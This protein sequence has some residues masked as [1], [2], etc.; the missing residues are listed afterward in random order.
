RRPVRSLPGFRSVSRPVC[1]LRE[2]TGHLPVCQREQKD[3]RRIPFVHLSLPVQLFK[4]LH[5]RERALQQRPHAGKDRRFFHTP[6]GFLIFCPSRLLT[7]FC[8]RHPDPFF[9]L[10]HRI[11]CLTTACAV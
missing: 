1:C 2:T 8:E 11:V 10:T 9:L 4:I 5:Q 7:D 3:V 6:S